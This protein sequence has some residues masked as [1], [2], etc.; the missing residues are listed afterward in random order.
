MQRRVTSHNIQKFVMLKP[1]RVSGERYLQ[2]NVR[3]P[4]GTMRQSPVYC[5]HLFFFFFCSSSKQYF[6]VDRKQV[7]FFFLFVIFSSLLYLSV[8]F[9]V[10]RT[11]DAFYIH[12]KLIIIIIVVEMF[13]VVAKLLD[14]YSLIQQAFKPIL[15][16]WVCNSKK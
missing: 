3:K 16:K 15:R 10:G 9:C 8:Y 5:L 14:K 12:I 1:T 13:L 4:K 11:G 7:R 6:C 2:K